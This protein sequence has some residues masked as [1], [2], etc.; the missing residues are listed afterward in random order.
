MVVLKC[1]KQLVIIVALLA[2]CHFVPRALNQ[3]CVAL[4]LRAGITVL[5]LGA[6]A[7]EI[8]AIIEKKRCFRRFVTLADNVV[9]SLFNL[10][11][12]NQSIAV[13]VLRKIRANAM[14]KEKDGQNE[15][16]AVVAMIN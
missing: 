4:V 7:A 6:L 5:A 12:T 11:V 13:I 10:P 9:K 8:I 14:G 16:A 15:A 2:S 3:S 1:I